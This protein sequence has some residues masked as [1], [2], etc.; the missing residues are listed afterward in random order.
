MEWVLNGQF[1][2][3]SIEDLTDEE[4]AAIAWE[5]KEQQRTH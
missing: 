4:L 1:C 2:P 5:P 3:Q